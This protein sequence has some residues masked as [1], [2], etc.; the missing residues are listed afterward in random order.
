M[1]PGELRDALADLAREAEIDVRVLSG[2]GEVEPGLPVASGACRVRGRV[3][4]ILAARDPVEEHIEVLARALRTHAGA[5][6]EGRFLP[7]AVRER[8]EGAG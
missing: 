6:L 2:P 4:V 5:W 7:P 1:T 8:L 3:W